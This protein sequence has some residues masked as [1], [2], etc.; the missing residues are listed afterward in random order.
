MSYYLI[1]IGGTGARCLEAFVHLCGAGLLQKSSDVKMLFVDADVSCGN[2]TRAQSAATFYNKAQQIGFD[3]DSIFANKIEI[4]DAW[5]PVPQGC[6]TLDDVFSRSAMAAGNDRALNM[7][8]ESLFTQQE[9]QTPLDKGFRGHPAIGAAV[10]SKEILYV[11]DEP[12]K[13]LKDQINNDGEAKLFLF[14]SVFGG[15]GASGF[16]TI[17]RI[18]KESV[19][20]DSNKQGKVSIGGALVLPY[21]QLPSPPEDQGDELQAKGSDFIFN[22]KSALD[23]YDKS[24]LLG[25][26]FSSLYMVG[27]DDLP[28]V[29]K[30]SLGANTQKNDAHFIEL[31]AALAA[32]D[33]F[34]RDKDDYQGETFM[35]GRGNDNDKSEYRNVEWQDIPEVRVGSVRDKIDFFTRFLYAYKNCVL[36]G[37]EECSQNQNAEKRI[38]WYKDLVKKTGGIDVYQDKNIMDKFQELGNYAQLYFDWWRQISETGNTRSVELI[39]KVVMENTSWNNNNVDLTQ[40][41]LPQQQNK[42][43]L[44]YKEFWRR[45]CGYINTMPKTN[46]SGAAALMQAIYQEVQ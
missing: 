8:Y 31:Y 4:F 21:F 3:K 12:W 15:T 44:N 30:F 35:I 27:D 32:F 42:K 26:V 13:S 33:F 41:L 17:A 38:T 6:S 16:P 36:P 23:Y 10:M 7:L 20:K 19:H 1:G 40:V 14:A 24:G 46:A 9:R 29:K 45:L 39:S 28:L 11:D 2:L 25:T 43:P 34:N 5:N 22:T 37:L 18:L